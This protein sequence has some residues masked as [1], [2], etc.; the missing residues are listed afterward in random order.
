MS[1]KWR[2]DRTQHHCW[3]AGRCHNSECIKSFFYAK[4]RYTHGDG[5]TFSS[6]YRPSRHPHKTPWLR[7]CAH[8]REQ[9][10]ILRVCGL[11]SWRW[12]KTHLKHIYHRSNTRISRYVAVKPACISVGDIVELQVSFIMVPLRDN[13]FKVTMVLRSILVLDR[14]YTQVLSHCF[15]YNI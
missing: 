2:Q 13:K 5:I 9:S 7:F 10:V 14:T 6:R 15:I 11:H 4:E 1:G 8:R 3:T 12:H